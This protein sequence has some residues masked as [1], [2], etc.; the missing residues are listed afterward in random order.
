[1]A[2]GVILVASIGMHS[3]ELAGLIVHRIFAP[4]PAKSS[5]AGAALHKRRAH[6]HDETVISGQWCAGRIC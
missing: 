6:E 3:D 1:M 2:G 4:T 5:A